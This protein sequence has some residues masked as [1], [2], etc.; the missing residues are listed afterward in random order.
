MVAKFWRL[1]ARFALSSIQILVTPY[2]LM[3]TLIE[4]IDEFVIVHIRG[5]DIEHTVVRTRLNRRGCRTES[6]PADRSAYCPF[7]EAGNVNLA[8]E[9]GQRRQDP[10]PVSRP[11][12]IFFCIYLRFIWIVPYFF[13]SLAKS[14]IT[15]KL[16]GTVVLV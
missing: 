12:R 3:L 5:A 9:R 10:I 6:W 4:S 13:E 15:S 1:T 2:V 7:V 8:A 14:T 11:I 16:W